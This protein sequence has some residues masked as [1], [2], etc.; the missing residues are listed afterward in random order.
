MLI[1]IAVYA[2]HLIQPNEFIT[3]L[4]PETD[5][6]SAKNAIFSRD[7]Y[8]QCFSTLYLWAHDTSWSK[9]G[10]LK[11]DKLKFLNLG[12]SKKKQNK[13]KTTIQTIEQVPKAFFCSGSCLFSTNGVCWLTLM[14]GTQ[15]VT[16]VN[17]SSKWATKKTKPGS[18]F[19]LE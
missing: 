8:L 18:I 12:V 13:T 16:L 4:I 1:K 17:N 5:L 10:C 19:F 3:G 14:H 7:M 6:T 11:E 15:R 9:Q 2:L